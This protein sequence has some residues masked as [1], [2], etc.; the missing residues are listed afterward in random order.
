MDPMLVAFP[1]TLIVYL[2]I[3]KCESDRPILTLYGQN[4]GSSASFTKL[5]IQPEL[6]IALVR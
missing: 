6:M 3:V 2:V 4:D 1:I 5:K